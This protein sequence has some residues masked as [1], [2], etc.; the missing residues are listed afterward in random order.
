MAMSCA[1][2]REHPAARLAALLMRVSANELVPRDERLVVLVDG[3]DEYDPPAGSPTGDPL[4]A[5]LP[6]AL[7]RG[8]SFLCASRPRHPYLSMLKTRGGIHVSIDLDAADHADDNTATVRAVWELAAPRLGCGCA[9]GIQL[10]GQQRQAQHVTARALSQMIGT[11]APSTRLVVLNAC[12]SDAAAEAVLGVVGCVVGMTGAIGDDAAR[13]FAVGFYRA[14]GYRRSVGNAVAQAVATLAAKQLP[15][16]HLPVCR[17]Q[18]RPGH[19]AKPRPAPIAMTT[20]P[21]SRR[22]PTSMPSL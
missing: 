15:D 20:S 13:S 11:A 12:F 19:H 2:A 8:V 7:P 5:F 18:R 21:I 4:S 3:L 17:H 1:D 16:E 9:A 10:Q 22:S 14:L 6:H